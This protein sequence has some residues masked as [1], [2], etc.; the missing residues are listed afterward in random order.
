M[1]EEGSE[2]ISLR[3]TASQLHALQTLA[4]KEHISMSQLLRRY[5]DKGMKIDGYQD[6]TGFIREQI[7]EEL[8]AQFKPRMERMLRMG[9]QATLYSMVSSQL[10][11]EAIESLVPMSKQTDAKLAIERATKQALQLCARMNPDKHEPL[12]R[13]WD[14]SG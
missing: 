7:R 3:I 1:S 14:D 4:A 13:F 6:Q 12:D 8:D 9:Y 11:A 2:R 5:I 10:C